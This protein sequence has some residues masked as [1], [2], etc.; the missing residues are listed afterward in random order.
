[1]I[2]VISFIAMAAFQ[3]RFPGKC[4]DMPLCAARLGHGILVPASVGQS[5][6]QKPCHR[7]HCVQTGPKRFFPLFLR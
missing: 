6:L 3:V 7:P 1:M 4:G 2:A 5:G